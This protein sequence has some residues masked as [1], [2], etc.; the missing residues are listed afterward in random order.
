MV[1]R[2]PLRTRFFIIHNP[3]AGLET[4]TLYEGVLSHLVRSGCHIEVV[5]TARHGEGMAAAAHAARSGQFDAAVAAGGDGTI[6]DVAEG[7]LGHEMPLG[8]IPI[9]TANVF[10]QELGLP[11]EPEMLADALLSAP[12]RLIPL[13]EANGRPFLFVVGVGFDAEAV[14]EFE[15]RCTR[16]YGRA[17]L[18]EPVLRALWSHRDQALRVRTDRQAGEARWVIVT[19][20]KRYAADL[21][22]APEAD[23]R[24]AQFHVLRMTGRGPFARIAQLAALGVG[25]LRFCPGVTLEVTRSVRIEGD[26]SVPVQIDG[27]LL[28]QLPLEIKIHPR[29]LAVILP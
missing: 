23:L 11:R 13:G 10:A 7:I 4:R 3:K 14:R 1:G 20:T 28:G 29:Q 19:R 26:Q 2:I 17:G 22:L 5:E 9:G 27:E 18:V 21:M 8:I 12:T 24:D 6:H 15:T 25:G 16:N